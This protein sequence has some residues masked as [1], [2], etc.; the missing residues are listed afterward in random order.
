MHTGS[1][2]LKASVHGLVIN[3]IHSLCTCTD[4]Y[5]SE[6]TQ[7]TLR[8][9]LDEFSLE[10]YSVLFGINKIE[11]TNAFTTSS[12]AA[13]HRTNNMHQCLPD[14]QSHHHGVFLPDFDRLQHIETI[15][16]SFLEIMEECMKNIKD[17]DWL[18]KWLE[19]AKMIAFKYNPALQYK[20]LI[21]YS[22]IGS[23]F[24]NYELK[25]MFIFLIR[26]LES[27]NNLQ[28]IES[29]IMGFTRIQ[30]ALPADS[31]IHEVLFWVAIFVL[32][33]DEMDLYLA[34]LALLE[35]NL[36]TLDSLGK[37]DNRTVEQVMMQAREPLEWNFKQLEI[38][39]GLSFKSNFHFALVGHLIKTYRLDQSTISR[40]LR[41]LN[42]LLNILSKSTGHDKFDVTPDNIAYLTALLPISEEVQS[43]C[44]LKH[45]ITRLISTTNNSQ[46]AKQQAKETK[47]KP[48]VQLEE[49]TSISS[50]ILKSQQSLPLSCNPMQIYNNQGAQ[51]MLSLDLNCLNRKQTSTDSHEIEEL[52]EQKTKQQQQQQQSTN[53]H[54]LHPVRNNSHPLQ[55]PRSLSPRNTRSTDATHLSN[56]SS[57]NLNQEE[58]SS[59]S[60]LNKKDERKFTQSQRN[61]QLITTQLIDVND[62]NQ[63]SE[64]F[65]R[66]ASSGSSKVQTPNYDSSSKESKDNQ[67][68]LSIKS[69]DVIVNEENNVVNVLLDPEVIKD[70]K[71]QAL[72]LAV[73][74]TLVRN[75][76]D[77]KETR[78]L[79]EY[80]AEGSVVFSK[81]FPVIHSLL[82]AKLTSVLNLCH[83]QVT[84]RAV[85]NIIQ[86]MVV[87]GDIGQQQL[88]YLYSVGFGGLWRFSGPFKASNE[89]NDNAKQFM[90]CLESLVNNYLPYEV[91]ED[92]QSDYKQLLTLT[93]SKSS[94][95]LFTHLDHGN[96]HNR[97][98]SM[99]QNIQLL[100]STSL[101]SV[102][103]RN[104]NS[105]V[106]LKK[107]SSS[108]NDLIISQD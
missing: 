28:L 81:T 65:N 96:R 22:C 32:Q 54:Y 83:D 29:I 17:C 42:I 41:I 56:C 31:P 2:S 73:L 47:L 85:Q 67:D 108:E 98:T 52:N 21:V 60:A 10:K 45:K 95:M 106:I 48:T 90:K 87:G 18:D 19:L 76:N 51:K 105:T 50:F 8:L 43:R 16:D 66:K 53:T 88:H 91:E 4:P 100:N 37:F 23:T 94:G 27:F 46:F 99:D 97:Q 70:E 24:S 14:S 11:S 26:S 82:D 12:N 44:H 61:V 68:K 104:K 80:L 9:A 71:I 62:T 6:S 72:V 36:H 107:N 13:F 78:I 92:S 74:A 103:D 84:I 69:I 59:S 15:T 38:S 64:D 5:F 75:T 89:C 20:G 30:P 79:Y 63:S 49:S 33:L 1:P 34:G 55:R 86:N 7:C 3:I 58:N 25:Q 35:Q 102:S 57:S 40:A 93:T 39:I 77:E 101:S